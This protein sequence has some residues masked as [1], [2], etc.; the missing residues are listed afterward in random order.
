MVLK[1]ISIETH[2]YAPIKAFHLRVLLE[3]YDKCSE[4]ELRFGTECLH[5]V[6]THTGV[7]AK[8]LDGKPNLWKARFKNVYSLEWGVDVHLTTPYALAQVTY[9]QDLFAA[10]SLI[11]Q[12]YRKAGP[13]TAHAHTPCLNLYSH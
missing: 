9:Q 2:I 3:A 6:L 12:Q 7:R 13:P 11:K 10:E 4:D 1:F 5:L 8:L